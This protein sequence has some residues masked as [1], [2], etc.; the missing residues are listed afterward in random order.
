MKAE[1]ASTRIPAG[2]AIHQDLSRQFISLCTAFVGGSM[3]LVGQVLPDQPLECK[4]LLILAWAAAVTCI[5]GAAGVLNTIAA[6]WGQ[7]FKEETGDSVLS[8]WSEWWLGKVSDP[9]GQARWRG[10]LRFWLSL[11][12]YSFPIA[13]SLFMWFAWVNLT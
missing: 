10:W 5:V 11:Q 2:F 1:D 8:A 7:R 4:A 13:V 12:W 6:Y 9:K 3:F